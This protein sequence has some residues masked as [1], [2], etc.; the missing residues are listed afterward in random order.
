MKSKQNTSS[1][2]KA[3]QV[4]IMVIQLALSIWLYVKKEQYRITAE[5]AT[6]EGIRLAEQLFQTRAQISVHENNIELQ[7]MEIDN[8][9]LIQKADRLLTEKYYQQAL[10][11]QYET[12]KLKKQLNETHIISLDDDEHLRF[13]R[14]WAKQ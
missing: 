13:F 6:S 11:Y 7:Q 12:D 10:I 1:F 9:L 14:Q 5:I 8:L 4:F 2:W 3:A